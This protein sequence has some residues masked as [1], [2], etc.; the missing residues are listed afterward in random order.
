LSGYSPKYIPPQYVQFANTLLQD[1]MLF[2]SDYPFIT[3]ERWLADFE[4]AGF[5]ESVRDKI[6]LLNARRVLGLT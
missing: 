3:P 5:R 4:S 2:G 1:Q 6:L